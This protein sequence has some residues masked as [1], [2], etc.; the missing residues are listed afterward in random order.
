[1]PIILIVTAVVLIGGFWLFML[2]RLVSK[3]TRELAEKNELLR[4]A[5]EGLE[6]KVVK[7]TAELVNANVMLQT[8]ITERKQAED[9]KETLMHNMGERVKEL[10]CLYSIAKS[11]RPR[12]TVKE[13]FMDIVALI[14]QGWHY[15]D[16]TR[17]KIRFEGQDYVTEPFE[18]TE[19]R[20]T[21]DILI[22][23]KRSG[24][25]EVYY[26]E[27]HPEL[28]EGPF[29]SEERNL[30]D[31]IAQTLSE[32]IERKQAED[33]REQ[34]N[35]ELK[36]SNKELEQFA[37]IASHDLR[38][39]LISISGFEDLLKKDYEDKLDKNAHEYIGFIV[40]SIKRME[41]LIHG[42]LTYSRIGVSSIKLK[43]VDVNKVFV[44]AIANLTLDIER[45]R[46]KITCDSLPSVLGD[47]IQL[48]QLLQN[49]I[50]NAIKFHNNESPGVHLSVKQ[51]GGN[52]V[53]SVKDNGIGIASENREKIFDMFQCLDRGN[54]KGTGIGLAACKKIVELHGGKIWVESQLNTGSIFYFTIPVTSAG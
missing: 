29:L 2:K 37:Y 31:G 8:E 5:T 54:Y 40:N 30:I 13:I 47:D 36:Q 17:G 53:F 39:P 44:R 45:N 23:G 7:R 20:Q 50:G 49:L 26:L 12:E 1:M 22:N 38:S 14:P 19:W 24:S 3:R 4:Q 35:T 27:E 41:N 10:Q 43:T 32:A 25:V 42:L 46:A 16:I 28:D 33:E 11:I 18:E 34:L 21:S 15:P 52:W 48:E 9:E 51:K 6:A